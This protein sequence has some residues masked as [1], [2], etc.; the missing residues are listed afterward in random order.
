MTEPP[1]PVAK[2]GK[3]HRGPRV[4]RRAILAASVPALGVTAL[5]LWTIAP[6]TGTTPT[7]A[8]T[9]TP[10]TASVTRQDLSSQLTLNAT[11]GYTGSY[12]I[13]SQ[14]QP[15]GGSGSGSAFTSLPVVGQLIDQ[16]QS[17]YAVNGTPVVLLYGSTPAWRTLS[18]GATGPDVAELNADL[19]NLGVATTA[20]LNPTSDCFGAATATA[21]EKLQAHLGASQTGSLTL[22]QVT[23]LPT[24][25]RVTTVSANLGATVSGGPVLAGTSPTREVSATLPATQRSQVHTGDRVTIT[26]A[27]AHATA[28]VVATVGATATSR[29]GGSGASSP[30]PTVQVDITPTDPAATGTVDQA[31]VT[32][33]VTTATVK[34][35]LAVPATALVSTASGQPGIEVVDA[36]HIIHSVHVTPG[37]FDD[38]NG[39]VQITGTGLDVGQHI[40][41]PGQPGTT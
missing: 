26:L 29:G 12:T 35:V 3:R 41:L 6:L 31:P 30:P 5:V 2:P 11:V 23:F 7:A 22:G 1:D 8:G 40:A 33:A 36:N 32:V 28:G 17:L 24:A 10:A 21:V 14:G 25:V 15:S 9:R 20:Q 18:E 38:A 4:T 27:A 39:L 19:V 34:S 16:G 13:S 37:L